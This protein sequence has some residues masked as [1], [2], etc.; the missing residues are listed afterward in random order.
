VARTDTGA[1]TGASA[2][3]GAGAEAGETGTDPAAAT[4]GEAGT[5]LEILRAGWTADVGR[6]LRMTGFARRVGRMYE[7][8]CAGD[9]EGWRF[10][11]LAATP[12]AA[13]AGLTRI[14]HR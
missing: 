6:S 13:F 9:G 12:E 8:G 7:A 3:A 2:G 5:D 11:Y 1:E 14:A 10:S 4:T